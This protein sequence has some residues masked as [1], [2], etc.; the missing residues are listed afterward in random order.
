VYLRPRPSYK[1]TPP[2]PVGRLSKGG[3]EEE[4]V[5]LEE[6]GDR[7]AVALVGGVGGVELGVELGEK[8]DGVGGEGGKVFEGQDMSLLLLP[9]TT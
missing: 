6:V 7:D 5:R 8:G 2:Q 4:D 1:A 3:D 9:L